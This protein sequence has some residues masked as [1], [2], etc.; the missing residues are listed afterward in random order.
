MKKIIIGVMLL[1]PLMLIAQKKPQRADLNT[2]FVCLDSVT[3]NRLFENPFVRDTLFLCRKQSA[4]TNADSY[5]GKYFIGLAGTLEFFKPSDTQKIGD[6]YGDLGIEFK[7]RQLKTLAGYL[8]QARENRIGASVETVTADLGGKKTKWYNE[9]NIKH[10]TLPNRF[11]V[12]VIEY[13]MEYLASQGFSAAAIASPMTYTQYNTKLAGGRK[14]PRQFNSI[15]KINIR[16]SPREFAY[17]KQVMKV[18]GFIKNHTNFTGYGVT[19]E[20]TITSGSPFR[21]NGVELDLIDNLPER[22][23]TISDHL[24]LTV[25]QNKAKLLFKND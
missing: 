3:Y 20:F 21:L 12:S 5:T 6:K 1:L 11:A 25:K 10:D 7:T 15:R 14:Y 8:K 2:V 22:N 24:Q 13:Q 16:L 23:I 17:L 18:M 19:I 9:L 4:S